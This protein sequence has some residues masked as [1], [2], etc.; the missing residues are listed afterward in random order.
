MFELAAAMSLP[1]NSPIG[2]PNSGR[3][4]YGEEISL[5]FPSPRLA[6]FF[7]LCGRVV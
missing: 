5:M 6:K 7:S 3:V 1:V 2:A 4:N